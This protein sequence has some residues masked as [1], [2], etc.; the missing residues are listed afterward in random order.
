VCDFVSEAT[1]SRFATLLAQAAQGDP[2]ALAE[3]SNQY[4]PKVRMVARVLLG[5]AL[6]PYLE[7]CDLAQSVHKSIMIGLRDGRFSI[8][9]PD[10]LV[11]LALTVLRRKA[12]RHWR[13]VRRQN[14]L[15]G[16]AT[17]G[18]EGLEGLLES[19][20]SSES[21]PANAVQTRDQIEQ[22]CA[23]LDEVDRRILEAMLAGHSQAEAAELVSVSRVALRVR[24]TRLRQR[25]RAA[26]LTLD[27]L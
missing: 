8:D 10:A 20:Q 19:L 27:W 15:S 13:Q 6:R 9:G 5:P 2:A 16:G 21:D 11:A 26:G 1:N 17:Q 25:V 18:S 23:H 14:R 7:S 4:A 22:L 24:L 12:G 3:L